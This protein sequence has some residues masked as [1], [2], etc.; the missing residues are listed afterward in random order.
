MRRRSRPR[1]S[2]AAPVGEKESFGSKKIKGGKVEKE[3]N[4]EEGGGS[5]TRVN[6]E[7]S[8]AETCGDVRFRGVMKVEPGGSRGARLDPV[9]VVVTAEKMARRWARVEG[10]KGGREGGEGSKMAEGK[11]GEKF[12]AGH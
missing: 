4:R 11:L 7:L 2:K 8:L 1:G 6:S 5:P 10:R 12:R 3:G 9:G